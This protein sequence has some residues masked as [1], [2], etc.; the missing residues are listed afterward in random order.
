MPL[1]AISVWG[2]NDTDLGL[3]QA[4]QVMAFLQALSSECRG[5]DWLNGVAVD[6][7]EGHEHRVYRSDRNSR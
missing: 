2:G 5:R 4:L 1:R 7:V 6:S 3:Q